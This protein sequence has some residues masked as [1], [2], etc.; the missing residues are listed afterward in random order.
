MIKKGDLVQR[1]D[2]TVDSRTY[3]KHR[4]GEVGLVVEVNDRPFRV[5]EAD[6]YPGPSDKYIT[7]LPNFWKKNKED[8]M[9]GQ[10]ILVQTDQ[11]VKWWEVKNWTKVQ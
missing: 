10:A 1:N 3:W 2:S 6:F 4:K 7:F 8:Y 5:I 11:D 9:L